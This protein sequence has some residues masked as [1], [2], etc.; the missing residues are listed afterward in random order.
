MLA[1]H[2]Y[3]ASGSEAEGLALA[4]ILISFFKE[5]ATFCGLNTAGF[6][7]SYVHCCAVDVLVITMSPS[8][9]SSLSLRMGG[10]D[11]GE[12][13]VRGFVDEMRFVWV[14]GIVKVGVEDWVF[15]QGERD[16]FDD[17]GEGGDALG[18]F[19]TGIELLSEC[20]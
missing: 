15:L 5:G 1:S 13:L 6:S 16:G 12:V 11:A 4:R 7:G 19:F 18:F 9:S 3:L 10:D 8:S 2:G 14:G 17:E 20:L